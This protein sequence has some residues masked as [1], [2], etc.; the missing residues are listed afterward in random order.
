MTELRVKHIKQKI[1][2]PIKQTKKTIKPKDLNKAQWSEIAHTN[3]NG[4][5]SKRLMALQIAKGCRW[6]K[7]GGP[8][9]MCNFWTRNNE[10]VST[11]NIINQFKNNIK[12]YDFQ[13]QKIEELDAF[14]AGSFLN[15]RELPEKARIKIMEIAANI[16]PIKKVMIESRPEYVKKQKIEKIKNIL[17]KKAFEI[18][19]GLESSQN[20]TRKY[21]IN[22]GFSLKS[23]EK[24]A[25]II[26]KSG[27]TLLAYVLVKPPFLT[28]KESIEDAIKTIKYVFN[29]S[30]KLKLKTTVALEPVFIKHP[31]LVY[32]LYK[33]GLYRHIWLW[34]IIKILKKTHKLGN[35]QIGLSSEGMNYYEMPR[36]CKKCT[37]KILDA[38]VKYN[39]LQ[40]ITV[41]NSINCR[42]TKNWENELRKK[43]IPLKK[44]ILNFSS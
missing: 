4:K 30:K 3:I 26:K 20:F 1:K 31:S 12:K 39:S 41:L 27:A 15:N 37:K 16:K 6:A 9:F 28:E 7:T 10:K 18:A 40:K 29:L 35:I 23:F 24:A 34:S 44:R 13:K 19:I 38:I 36:N 2:N 8:C 17:G 32:E 25:Q 42:C 5:P 33:K 11:E 21:C 43:I 14:Y 22:K